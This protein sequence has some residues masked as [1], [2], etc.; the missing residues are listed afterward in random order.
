MDW[1]NPYMLYVISAV[2][3]ILFFGFCIATTW[4]FARMVIGVMPKEQTNDGDKEAKTP[5][6]VS[7]GADS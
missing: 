4:L 2:A 5:N 1:S 7:G 6:K 3:I